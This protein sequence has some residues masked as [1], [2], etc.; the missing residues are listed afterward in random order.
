MGAFESLKDFVFNLKRL[1]GGSC[2]DS[3]S[4]DTDGNIISRCDTSFLEENQ[5]CDVKFSAQC[6][7]IMEVVKRCSF[8]LTIQNSQTMVYICLLLLQ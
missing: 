6:N 2:F 7:L 3:D 1:R 5:D 4:N 8:F